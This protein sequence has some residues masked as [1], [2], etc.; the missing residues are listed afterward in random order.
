MRSRPAAPREPD[1]TELDY[2]HGR[3]IRRSIWVTGLDFPHAAQVV[4]IRRDDYDITG[5]LVSKE[6][7]DAVTSLDA[8][9]ARPAD[10]AAI[11]RGQWGIESSN[12]CTG[13]GTP[14]RLRYRIHRERPA[15]PGHLQEPRD[16]PAAP[17]RSTQITRTLQDIGRDRNRMLSHLLL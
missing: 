2:G 5:A 12:R 6:I 14:R 9:R 11:A 17:G 13:Y 16:Q 10:L 15:G 3:I 4:W 1:Y 7:V 8:G